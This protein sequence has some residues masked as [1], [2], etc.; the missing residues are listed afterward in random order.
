MDD[1]IQEELALLRTRFPDLV[2]EPNGRWVRLLGY[3]LGDG[4]NREQDDIVFQIQAN[5][6]AAAPYGIYVRSGLLFGNARPGNYTEPAKTAPPFGG[7]WGLLSWTTEDPW[8]PKVPAG[9]GPNL[10]NWAIG[11][12]QRFKAGA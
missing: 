10:L 11:I 6:P 7:T 4:W 8:Q 9:K 12:A 3:P 1:R 2:Y 5:H